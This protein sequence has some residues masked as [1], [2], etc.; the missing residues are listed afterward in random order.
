[1]KVLRDPKLK[2]KL[3]NYD[4]EVVTPQLLRKVQRMGDMPT[5][6]EARSVSLATAAICAWI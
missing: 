6:N 5:A 2:A 1:M 4:M 3:L